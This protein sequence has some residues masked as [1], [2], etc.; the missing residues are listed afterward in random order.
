MQ[1]ECQEEDQEKKGKMKKKAE[2]N[3]HKALQNKRKWSMK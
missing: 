2:V 1:Q 3:Q